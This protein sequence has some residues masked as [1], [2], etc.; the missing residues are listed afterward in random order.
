MTGEPCESHED[1]LYGLCEQDS[2]NIT[3]GNF[4]VCIKK[5]GDCAAG[6]AAACAD[7]DVPAEQM[8]FTCVKSKNSKGAHISHCARRC[9]S[10]SGFP[11]VDN[12]QTLA[13]GY[14]SCNSENAGRDYCGG[15]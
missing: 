4:K 13:T 8:Y 6:F 12:C 1:C 3:G 10:S 2:P 14:T 5:C 11:G 9:D 15:Q 7:D